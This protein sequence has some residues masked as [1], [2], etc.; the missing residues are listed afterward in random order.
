MSRLISA[1][2]AAA[3]VAIVD[4]LKRTILEDRYPLSPRVLTMKAV[5]K[6][7]F[8]LGLYHGVVAIDETIGLR[9]KTNRPRDRI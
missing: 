9:L 5:L 4:L 6:N 8:K 3:S 7:L 1:R 2:S